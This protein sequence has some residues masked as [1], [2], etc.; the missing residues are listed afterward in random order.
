MPGLPLAASTITHHSHS[1]LHTKSDIFSKLQENEISSPLLLA[2][3][4]SLSSISVLSFAMKLLERF[5]HVH[6]L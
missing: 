6:G 3:P 1:H 5:V 4:V 2:P